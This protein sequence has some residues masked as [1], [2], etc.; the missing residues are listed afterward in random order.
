MLCKWQTDELP[1]QIS[2]F[3]IILLFLL[4]LF[5]LIF[6]V[7]VSYLWFDHLKMNDA[8]EFKQLG[9]NDA[10]VSVLFAAQIKEQAIF[11]NMMT[12][13]C[14]KDCVISF[15]NVDL[16]TG[17]TDCISRCVDKF[18]QF[19]QAVGPR[20]WEEQQKV[21]QQRYMETGNIQPK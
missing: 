21:M 4:F 2:F 19:S 6:P 3:L 17:E 20:Y 12:E 13:R 15:R 9:L 16:N 11:A 1:N 8:D 18:V 14:F 5:R 7:I 10:S